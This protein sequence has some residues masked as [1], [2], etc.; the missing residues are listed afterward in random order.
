MSSSIR[1][2]RYQESGQIMFALL[3]IYKKKIIQTSMSG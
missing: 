2:T 3:R 1:G